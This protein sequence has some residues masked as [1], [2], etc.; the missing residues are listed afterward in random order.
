MVLSHPF[1]CPTRVI[2]G[3]T[4]HQAVAQLLGARRWA[5]ITS[6]GWPGRGALADLTRLGSGP[7]AILDDIEP[8]PRVS[9]IV[10]LAQALPDIDVVVAFGGGSVLD[11][12][13]GAIALKALGNDQVALMAHLRDGVALPANMDPVPL[14]TIPTTSGTGSE[15][16]RWGTI[17][18]DDEVKYSINDAKLYPAYAVLDPAVCTSMPA[19]LTLGTALD[20]LSHAMEAVWNKHHSALTDGMAAQ[21]IRLIREN[22][23]AALEHPADVEIRRRMQTAAL[24]AGL[25]M[26]TT[27]TAL[28][29]SI[30]YPF[31]AKLGLPHGFACSFTLAEVARYNMAED[32]ARLGAI[33]SALGCS[34]AA[35]PQTLEDWFTELGVGK[36]L[37]RY[38]TAPFIESLS[39]DLISR[40]RAANNIRD[41]D[42][43]RARQLALAAFE[44]LCPAE[45][46][47][48][49]Q[50]SAMLASAE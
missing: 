35:V 44:K 18:G 8:N 15:V 30:S 24:S 16:T 1:S 12:A 37:G 13:K 17:W 48:G 32:G 33:A 45:S 46:G 7:A 19:E 5:L 28:A 38:V 34:L 25:A 40:A 29:H 42:G 11:A 39:G 43:A 2:E 27:Q 49:A 14:I 31:T 4:Y 23:A 20:A 3:H 10:Q 41:I 21:A 50:N 36:V 6:R 26:A 47:Q 22:L 9:S